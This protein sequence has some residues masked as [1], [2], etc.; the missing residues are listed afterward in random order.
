MFERVNETLPNLYHKYLNQQ[1]FF[2]INFVLADFL[3]SNYKEIEEHTYYKYIPI[4][5]TYRICKKFL[6]EINNDYLTKFDKAIALGIID[7]NF[8]D[9]QLNSSICNYINNHPNITVDIKHNISD[10]FN[11]CHEFIHYLNLDRMLSSARFYFSEGISMLSED[12][13]EKFLDK[14]NYNNDEYHLFKRNRFYDSYNCAKAVLIT[15][16]LFKYYKSGEIL[17][18]DIIKNILI[19]L[20][21]KYTDIEL[22]YIELK[23]IIGIIFG[24]NNVYFYQLFSHTLGI[25]ISK[26]LLNNFNS[27]G[28]I[29]YYNANIN[30]MFYE[31]FLSGIGLKLQLKNYRLILDELSFQKLFD[32]FDINFNT[33]RKKL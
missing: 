17:T 23:K 12:K 21:N 25:F 6:A 26:Y 5:E 14:E 9:N 24:S 28:L 7:I 16:Y 10:A 32:S 15:N 4:S 18:D 30:N 31:D 2:D 13:L 29:S 27:D 3:V 1:P 33:Y 20:N 8:N 19:E 11:T 22:D